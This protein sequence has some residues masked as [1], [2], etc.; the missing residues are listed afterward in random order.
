MPQLEVT[1]LEVGPSDYTAPGRHGAG[2][3]QAQ[4]TRQFHRPVR[5]FA[6]YVTWGAS[7]DLMIERL[8]FGSDIVIQGGMPSTLFVADDSDRIELEPHGRESNLGPRGPYGPGHRIELVIEGRH[9]FDF[10]GILIGEAWADS[11]S[12]DAV[13]KARENTAADRYFCAMLAHISPAPPDVFR[14][15][16]S[17]IRQV[18]RELAAEWIKETEGEP[19]APPTF[20]GR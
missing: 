8:V 19:L 2:R 13:R 11:D 10:R 5:P 7:P 9:G 18:A 20:R 6:F 17:S 12:D 1:A 4:I 16:A 15:M 14:T 3:T